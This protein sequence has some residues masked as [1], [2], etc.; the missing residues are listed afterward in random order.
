M[1]SRRETS[2]GFASLL[3]G[4]VMPSVASAAPTTTG[5]LSNLLPQPTTGFLHALG[6]DGSRHPAVANNSKQ[7]HCVLT[8]ID[9]AAGR[10][11]QTPFPMKKAHS[12]VGLGDGRVL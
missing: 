1:P 7:P 5:L 8:T 12:A 4:L 2:L 10:L 9:L 6:Y 11:R 3:A